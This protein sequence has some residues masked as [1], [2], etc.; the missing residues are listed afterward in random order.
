MTPLQEV[1][2]RTEKVDQL[3]TMYSSLR[4]RYEFRGTLIQILILAASLGLFALSIAEDKILLRVGLEPAATREW[5]AVLS[6]AVVLAAI[7]EMRL[8]YRGKAAVLNEGAKRIYDL[9]LTF[10]P[11]AASD[12]IT[13]DELALLRDQYGDVMKVLPGLPEGQ[14]LPLKAAHKRKR[15]LS[16]LV[17]SYPGTPLWLLRFRLWIDGLS[18]WPSLE[19]L[20]SSDK[21]KAIA[22]SGPRN[23]ETPV[24]SEAEQA[25]E[26]TSPN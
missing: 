20:P 24:T 14:F 22:G 18:R 26:Q 1:A 8:D 19:S 25:P 5:M 2:D 4:D 12:V 15:R 9:K 21:N 7:I 6:G 11:A 3:A 16:D 10:K 23:D 17:T 13:N